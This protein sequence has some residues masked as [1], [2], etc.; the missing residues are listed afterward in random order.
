MDGQRSDVDMVISKIDEAISD[1]EQNV[2]RAGNSLAQANK[3]WEEEVGRL[4]ALKLARETILGPKPKPRKSNDYNLPS[5]DELEDMS[6]FEEAVVSIAKANGGWFYS[7]RAR[8]RLVE[9]GF[10]AE[11]PK[12]SAALTHRLKRCKRFRR[13]ETN[14]H[15]ELLPLRLE[16]PKSGLTPELE[17]KLDAYRHGESFPD[18]F[19]EAEAVLDDEP[20]ASVPGFNP[21]Q[22]A[23][24]S[25]HEG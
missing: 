5:A 21:F 7:R 18:S 23:G 1:Q 17:A 9:A 14:G 8:P 11:G 3:R 19:D 16:A 15:Y 12:G 6:S 4:G 20:G 13:M 25:Q 10:L 2:T 22:E 24:I